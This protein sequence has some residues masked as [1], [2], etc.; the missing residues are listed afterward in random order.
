[1]PLPVLLEH[2]LKVH[3]SRLKQ[4]MEQMRQLWAEVMQ[5]DAWRTD[6]IG[7]LQTVYRAFESELV[8]H[9][10]KEERIVFSTIRRVADAGASDAQSLK[11][12]IELLA[13]EHGHANELMAKMRQM[14][15]SSEPYV[16]ASASYRAMMDCLKAMHADLGPHEQLE[17]QGLF[18]RIL[19]MCEAYCQMEPT[20]QPATLQRYADL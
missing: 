12:V 1:V 15:G 18:P 5:M 20:Q 8:F 7:Q 3:H 6:D 2:I 19:A 17:D 10:T 14:T 13:G 11:S 4:Q 16:H 9:I